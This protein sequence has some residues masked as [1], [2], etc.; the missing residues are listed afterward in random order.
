MTHLY[1]L[2]IRVCTFPDKFKIA[3]VLPLH[4]S[5]DRRNRNNYR[6][7]S[8]LSNFSK[9]VEKVIKNHLI[10]YLEDNNLLSVNHF[11]FRP[12]IGT[13]VPLYKATKHTY[14]YIHI[15]NAPD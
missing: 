10:K 12:G 3:V 4:K 8:M 2:S 14:I 1:N 15:C 11:G 5:G 6:P 13:D 9:I 7:I